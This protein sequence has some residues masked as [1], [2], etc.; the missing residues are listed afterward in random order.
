MKIT[1]DFVVALLGPLDRPG[2]SDALECQLA[3]RCHDIGACWNVLLGFGGLSDSKHQY[4]RRVA[5][6]RCIVVN[7]PVLRC[8]IGTELAISDA[9]RRSAN[10]RLQV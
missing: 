6:V 1:A 9:F 10:G 8:V 5:G 2:V 4:T 7:R 3:Q